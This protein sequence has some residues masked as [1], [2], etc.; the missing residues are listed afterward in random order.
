MNAQPGLGGRGVVLVP[1]GLLVA[2]GLGCRAASR[3]SPELNR[4][5]H[6][7]RAAT[8]PSD[9]DNLIEDELVWSGSGVHTGWRFSHRGSPEVIVSDAERK[10]V[11]ADYRCGRVTEGLRCSK[12][13]AGDRLEVQVSP[14]SSEDGSEWTVELTG[15]PD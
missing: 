2:L 13:L 5:R 8:V 6:A 7:A 11:A 15:R 1:V 3:E 4:E 9:A 10:L 14:S 12:F